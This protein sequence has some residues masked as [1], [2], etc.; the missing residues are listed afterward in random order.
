M[1]TATDVSRLPDELYAE[2]E[3]LFAS[4]PSGM[5][6]AQDLYRRLREA[7]PVHE[8]PGVTLLTRYQDVKMFL[9]GGEDTATF[10]N[11]AHT[12]GTYFEKMRSGLDP[13]VQGAYDEVL[14]FE[15]LV[16]SRQDGEAHARLRRIAQ[17]AFTPR[18][19]AELET[20]AAGYLDELLMP[21]LG[22]RGSVDLASVLYRLPMMVTYDL[23]GV[24]DDDRE[25]V[26]NWNRLI[27]VNVVRGD[28]ETVIAAHR[29]HLELREYVTAL[30]RRRSAARPALVAQF[31]DANRADRLTDDE[32][33]AMFS[34]LLRG[35]QVTTTSLIMMG[36]LEL[37]RNPAQWRL[38][39]TEPE[40]AGAATEELL[41]YVPPVHLAG[42][43]PVVDVLVAGARIPAGTTV[44]GVIPAANRDPVVFDTPE[45][46]DITRENSHRHLSL[47]FGIHH[48]LG[49]SLA[50]LQ[51]R[52]VFRTLAE[53]FPEMEWDGGPVELVGN[54]RMPELKSLRVILGPQ[55]T[56]R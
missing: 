49:A 8:L 53:R 27:E 16:M 39:C 26:R 46:L 5:E 1:T 15:S 55:R 4:D 51:G 6:R 38:L 28:P 43:L 9:Q 18:R 7:G 47:G 11:Q 35:G 36:L 23:L 37:L 29:A 40:R 2:A 19:I 17:S 33:T 44:W 12:R 22:E 41:R 56:V 3:C 32:L 14:R 52:L 54:V 10:L 21:L 42:K 25:L 31:V 24:P 34:V 50:R 30:A 48:C 20:T 45:T 13:A